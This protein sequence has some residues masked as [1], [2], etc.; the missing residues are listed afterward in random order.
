MGRAVRSW[1]CGA[2]LAHIEGDR[3]GRGKYA[4]VKNI[5]AATNRITVELQ[6]GTERTFDPRRQRGVTIYR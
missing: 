4:R 6:N 5:D 3:I 1:G 2:L